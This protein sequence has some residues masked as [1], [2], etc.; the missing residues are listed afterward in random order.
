MAWFSR[1]LDF[2]NP[3]RIVLR[4]VRAR[5]GHTVSPCDP[6]PVWAVA[7]FNG[8]GSATLLDSHG[9]VEIGTRGPCAAGHPAGVECDLCRGECLGEPEYP[10]GAVQLP[11]HA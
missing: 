10:P 5:G 7:Q 11:A 6:E 9:P 4:A 1:F 3:S 2:I 8:D